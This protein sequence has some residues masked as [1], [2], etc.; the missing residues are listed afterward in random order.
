MFRPCDSILPL[1]WVRQ[2]DPESPSASW[3]P[4]G[5]IGCGPGLFTQSY[6]R[7]SGNAVSVLLQLFSGP[8]YI[9]PMASSRLSAPAGAS[10]SRVPPGPPL[11]AIRR[12]TPPR[13]DVQALRN[14]SGTMRRGEHWAVLGPNGSG[15]STLVQMMQ[16]RLWPQ[17]GSLHVLGRTFGEDDVAELRTRIAWV[18]NEVE[19]EFPEWQTVAE[20]AA[21]GALGTLGVQF[22]APRKAHRQAAA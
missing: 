13:G 12:V 7:R 17:E 14:R 4:H 3:A 2:G 1:P 11:L 6:L 20:I 9:C 15:K 10:S 18:G 8:E 19:P 22:E 21:S 5:L 16:G